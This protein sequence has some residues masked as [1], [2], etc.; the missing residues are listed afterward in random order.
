MKKSQVILLLPIIGIIA[1]GCS[2]KDKNSTPN[3]SEYI[4]GYQEHS[5]GEL[6][7]TLWVNGSPT[8]LTNGDF[9]STANDVAKSNNDIYIAG[10]ERDTPSASDPSE[11]NQR[12]VYWKNGT[13][14]ELT[15]GGTNAEASGIAVSG[16]DV[17]VA[18]SEYNATNSRF[19]ARLWKNGVEVPLN[20]GSNWSRAN[21]VAVNGNDVYV[22]GN[23]IIGGT[24]TAILW[25]NGTAQ[26]LSVPGSSGNAQWIL[27]AGSDLYVF[28][29]YSNA[30]ITNACYW[31]NGEF[32]NIDFLAGGGSYF[33]NDGLLK[34][35]NLY[36]VGFGFEASTGKAIY[37][38]NGTA[39]KL[40]ESSASA[41][42][43]VD[44]N[45]VLTVVGSMGEYPAKWE[46]QNLAFTGTTRGMFNKIIYQ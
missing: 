5:S 20:D 37:W 9:A 4:A 11:L 7:A 16:M 8:F 35:G 44:K 42:S 13:Q 39:T 30:G 41:Q 34:S 40:G 38:N 19:N 24:P 33:A 18:G 10:A 1:F 36:L 23:E 15:D 31:K 45:N 3:F 27:V 12:A 46:N 26:P 17:Y 29:A 28:G 6:V 14:V 43:I 2:K 21:D 22:A 32:N 25:V